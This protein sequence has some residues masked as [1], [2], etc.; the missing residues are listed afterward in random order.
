MG[1]VRNDF[2]GGIVRLHRCIERA[3]H[4][5]DI[6]GLPSCESNQELPSVRGLDS[7]Q[8]SAAGE[9]LQARFCAGQTGANPDK[10]LALTVKE[11]GGWRLQGE[12]QQ[13]P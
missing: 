12:V 1:T 6:Q 8:R 9:A 5:L 13:N 10:M 3:E 4:F 7:D 2:D 11:D